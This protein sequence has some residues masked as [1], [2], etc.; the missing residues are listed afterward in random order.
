[1]VKNRRGEFHQNLEL[2]HTVMATE[3][4]L[5]FRYCQMLTSEMD[6]VVPNGG[7]HTAIEFLRPN[8]TVT[9]TV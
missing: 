4:F 5:L 1:M 3:Y 7:F 6:D 2:V 9:A 8:I